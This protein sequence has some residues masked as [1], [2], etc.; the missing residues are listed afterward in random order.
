MPI[1]SGSVRLPDRR[2][3]RDYTCH[4]TVRLPLRGTGGPATGF[5]IA[6]ATI[7]RLLIIS[8]TVASMLTP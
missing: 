5:R 1:P 4:A 6:P 2:A 3:S 8:I 7:L